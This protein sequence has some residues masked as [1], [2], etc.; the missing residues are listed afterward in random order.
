[1]SQNQNQQNYKEARLSPTA[2]EACVQTIVGV[3]N[4]D[5]TEQYS[6][7]SGIQKARVFSGSTAKVLNFLDF[8][9]SL[10][11]KSARRLRDKILLETNG[12]SPELPPYGQRGEALQILTLQSPTQ[13]ETP[14]IVEPKQ[15]ALSNE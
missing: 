9:I 13:K 7:D 10:G 1:M 2:A 11:S 8:Y 14:I 3:K 6:G 4:Y 12:A 15:E 5:I